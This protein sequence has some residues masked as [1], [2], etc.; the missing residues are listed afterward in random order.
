M[1]RYQYLNFL[2]YYNQDKILSDLTANLP[3]VLFFFIRSSSIADVNSPLINKHDEVSM[4][5]INAPKITLDILNI[6]LFF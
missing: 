1:P 6:Y 5:W 4:I 3:N 2:N